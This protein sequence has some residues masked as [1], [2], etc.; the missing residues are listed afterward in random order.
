M[1][2]EPWEHLDHVVSAVVVYYPPW[3]VDDC[4]R[5]TPETYKLHVHSWGTVWQEGV[6]FASVSFPEICHFKT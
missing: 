1:S 2:S 5:E 3:T 4:T 6:E